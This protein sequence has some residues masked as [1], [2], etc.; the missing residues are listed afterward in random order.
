[1]KTHEVLLLARSRLGQILV[2]ECLL[3]T[4]V[5]VKVSGLIMFSKA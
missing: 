4:G 1:M 2:L 5:T 3:G